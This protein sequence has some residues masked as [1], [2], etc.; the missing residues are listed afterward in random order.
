MNS[1]IIIYAFITFS[2]LYKNGN[3]LLHKKCSI[4]LLKNKYP[5]LILNCRLIKKYYQ[6]LLKK[7]T[8]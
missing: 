5:K 7:E 3:S 1:I 6:K 8:I 4:E 2:K